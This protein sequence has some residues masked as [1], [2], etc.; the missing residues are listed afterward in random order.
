MSGMKFI[1]LGLVALSCVTISFSANDVSVTTVHYKSG[2]DTVSSILYV[3][4]GKGPFPAIVV[5]HEWWGLVD[6]VKGNAKSM[7]ESGYVT[8]AIDLYRGKSA[9]SA[10][11]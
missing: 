9:A 4:G 10:D 1:W 6:W 8:L 5:I 11:D 7:A 2:K 3:P